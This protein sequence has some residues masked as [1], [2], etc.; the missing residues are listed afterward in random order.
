MTD[1]KNNAGAIGLSELDQ[2]LYRSLLQQCEREYRQ[3]ISKKLPEHPGNPASNWIEFLKFRIGQEMAALENLRRV[4]TRFLRAIKTTKTEDQKHLILNFARDLGATPAELK[5]D[6]A[7]F[8]RWFGAD[9][10]TDRYHRRHSR[11][12]QYAAFLLDRLAAIAADVARGIPQATEQMVFWKQLQLERVVKPLLVHDGDTRLKLAAFRCL[13]GAVSALAP[14]I[15]ETAVNDT[16]LRYVYRSALQ[17]QQ[18]VWIQCAA[19]ELLVTSSW[20][21]FERALW[22]R[23]LHPVPGDDLFVRR[24]AL[25]L[26]A[27]HFPRLQFG[28]TLIPVLLSDP[29]AF[30]RQALPKVLIQLPVSMAMATLER[31]VVDDASPQVRAAAWLEWPGLLAD[32][33]FREHALRLF[34][35]VATQETDEFVLR[36]ICLVA[37]RSTEELR[38]RQDL[39]LSEWHVAVREVLL[40][41][42]CRA[43]SVKVRR[44][45]SQA[46]EFIWSESH[47]E[48]RLLRDR[49]ANFARDIPR[50]QSRR[51][52]AALTEGLDPAFIGRLWSIV[53]RRDYDA[54]LQ[55]TRRGYEVIRGHVFGFRWW[56]WWHEFRHGSP[57]KRQAFRHTI[58][59]L[60][61]G[62]L[63][64]PS[65]I[66]AEL[67]Q[68]KVP[69]EP[70][71]ISAEGGWRP[72]LPLLDELTSC[73]EL[74]Q[75][76]QPF[77]IFTSEG[78]TVVTP[79]R[80]WKRLRALARL[81][82]H[83][84]DYAEKRNWLDSMQEPASSYLGALNDIGFD[85]RFETYA[86]ETG[87]A[88]PADPMVLRFFVQARAAQVAENVGPAIPPAAVPCSRSEP[89][90]ATPTPATTE[91][92]TTGPDTTAP[93]VTEPDTPEPAMPVAAEPVAVEATTETATTLTPEPVA[94]DSVASDEPK[95]SK[96]V[97]ALH[98]DS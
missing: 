36:V 55:I 27:R 81:T 4:Y 19:L 43:A 46:L 65:A 39:F 77:R 62:Q 48:A 22:K 88:L 45:A 66:M 83:F 37:E 26:L 63:H 79:P 2:R 68:T 95:S 10:I 90:P 49:F 34:R 30:V 8:S 94:P 86:D 73:I 92:V 20:V 61:D 69:G 60:F 50:G 64:I 75:T 54:Q 32:P 35:E 41:L 38:C 97:G 33:Q 44:W 15:Q 93:A 96:P 78:I 53:C 18:D 13:A 31:L 3:W 51:L 23:V 74:G 24:R 7:A 85:I 91:T 1:D 12:E 87:K 40:G 58:G 42:R 71:Q 9:A 29:S 76:P 67:A 28:Q 84:R 82:W 16:T 5:K 56:R 72:Y 59:R 57:D 21:C 89:G 6:A 25:Q 11:Y 14:E 80:G 70:L 47:P 52:P 98:S 17:H